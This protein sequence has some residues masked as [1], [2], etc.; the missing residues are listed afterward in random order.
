MILSAV[1]Y[2]YQCTLG[3]EITTT[4]YCD[5]KHKIAKYHMKFNR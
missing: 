5:L 2:A 4:V 3:D 1:V